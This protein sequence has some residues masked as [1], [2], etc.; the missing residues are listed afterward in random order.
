MR[1]LKNY[2]LI[3]NCIYVVCC[4]LLVNSH[5]YGV[6]FIAGNFFFYFA[7]NQYTL[8]RLIL[9][10]ANK[11]YVLERKKI[12]SF[13]F[14]NFIIALSLTPFF[15]IT[16]FKGALVNAEF[17]TWIPKPG[18]REFLYGILVLS[19]Y[20]SSKLFIIWANKYRKLDKNKIIL[21]KYAVFLVM[22]IYFAAYAISISFRNIFHFRYLSICLPFVIAILPIFVFFI[23]GLKFSISILNFYDFKIIVSFA[24]LSF[25][26]YFINN[27]WT[28][29][30]WGAGDNN[31]FKQSR[32]YI[33]KD[34]KNYTSIAKFNTSG[35]PLFITANY[36]YGEEQIQDYSKYNYYD[37][38]Y[39]NPGEGNFINGDEILLKNLNNILKI[40]PGGKGKT[41]YKIKGESKILDKAYR[42]NSNGKHIGEITSDTVIKQTFLS[43]DNNLCAITIMFATFAR[44]NTSS[45]NLRLYDEND[46]LINEEIIKNETM[47]DNSYLLYEFAKIEDSRKKKYT[48]VISSNDAGPGN[49]VT[50][51]CTDKGSFEGD[52]FINNQQQADDLCIIP[53]YMVTDVKKGKS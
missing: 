25:F 45:V 49:A 33:I 40:I 20:I 4:I 17:N 14:I 1:L 11:K 52:L 43:N 27:N 16:A 48:L 6:L 38:I 47:K 35:H 21:L 7:F 46:I 28:L 34:S 53:G 29:F 9:F 13:V 44:T 37:F 41:I 31:V 8:R 10:F 18:K 50:V 39:I 19:I 22:F 3:N 42:S 51:W 30:R 12:L 36:F 15:L 23:F 5:Y 2:N 24:L 32:E 26:S